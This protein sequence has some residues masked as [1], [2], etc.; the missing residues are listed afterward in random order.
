MNLFSYLSG[1]VPG[2]IILYLVILAVTFL[3]LLFMQRVNELFTR[4]H[5]FRWSLFT[6]IFYTVIYAAIWLNN[7]PAHVLKRYGI[8]IREEGQGHTWFTNYL[9]ETLSQHVH[10]HVSSRE[11]FF[12][13]SWYYRVT[14]VDSGASYTFRERIMSSM[15]VQRVLY[16]IIRRQN[17][18]FQV[19]MEVR[20]Y[21]SG[22][23]TGHA[24]AE[25]PRFDIREFVKWTMEEF[26]DSFP[27]VQDNAGIAISA[28]DSILE[29]AREFFY[30]AW[31][32]QCLETLNAV[33][34]SGAKNPEYDIW[35]Q[36]AEIKL[37]GAQSASANPVNPYGTEKPEWQQRLEK[38]RNR[39]L[40][41]LRLRKKQ[42]SMDEMVAESYIWEKDFSS[43]ELFLKKAFVDN[44][45]NIDVLLNLSF[46]HISRYREF[47]FSGMQEIYQRILDICP[48]EE[49]VLIRWCE[50]IL[51]N[52]PSFS[53]PP[54]FARKR[55]EYYLQMN[56]HSYRAW[57]ML[58]KIY[59]QGIK[60]EYTLRMF[61]KADSIAPE[62]AAV[63]YNIGVLYYEWGKPDLA[64]KYLE[65]AISLDD[66]LDAYLYLG[67]LFR[68]EGKYQQALELFRYRVA[69]KQGEDDFYAY[70]AMKGIQQCLEALRDKSGRQE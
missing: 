43:A 57:L 58:G 2:G 49:Q 45:F 38:A 56:P 40:D 1:H 70:Q 32:R 28:P 68:D 13:N 61:L 51:E 9:I 30:R 31:Y 33:N 36:Y 52:N 27:F 42:A 25:F 65:Q 15:P 35:R 16:G 63:S 26:A 19:E 66:Y 67:V 47:G 24:R 62:N 17:N 6:F 54:K 60:R 22:K 14:P 7:P 5:L 8:E 23:I 37:A 69:H 18:M 44:P 39:L 4:R 10:S 64:R 50:N 12:P 55:I 20:L 46:L 48:V 41:Y 59:A 29:T 3:I 34:P 21:P 11:Y 53:A